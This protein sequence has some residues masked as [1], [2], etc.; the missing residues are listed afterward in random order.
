MGSPPQQ[1][2]WTWLRVRCEE[3]ERWMFTDFSAARK[4]MEEIEAALRQDTPVDILAAYCSHRAFLENQWNHFE[5]AL[6]YLERALQSWERLNNDE[7]VAEAHLDI[8]AVH[9]NRRD[10]QAAEQSLERARYFLS[11]YPE[12]QRL[13]GQLACREGFLNLHLS[14]HRKA[15]EKLQE[16]ER[17]LMALGE[18]A[19]LKDFYILT[20]VISGLGDLY[21]RMDEEDS[22]LEAYLR[23]LPIVEQH[24]LRPR[25]PWHYLNAGRAAIAQ[26]DATYARECFERVLQF[27]NEEEIE[28]K[29]HALA[30]LGILALLQ[31][32]N[33]RAAL[34]FDEAAAQFANPSSPSDFTN[35]SKIQA[36]RAELLWQLHQTQQAE[37]HFEQAYDFGKRGHDLNHL[38]H[39]CQAL[40]QL[41][42]ARGDYK[43]AYHW[44]QQSTE[45]IEQHYLQ[46]RDRERQ[47]IEIRHN[48][49][50]IRQ[51][52]QLAK[53]RVASLQQRALRA[54]MNP[55]FLFNALNAIQGLITSGR[56][57]EAETYLARFAKL[58]RHTLEYS[59][60]EV[61]TLEQEIEFLERYLDLNRR[62]RFRNRLHYTIV[63]P[64][65]VDPAE[66]FIP[67]MIVQPFVENAIEHG[68]RPRL[69]GNLKVE[70][71]LM[72]DENTLLCL[73]EDD[74][75]GFNNGREKQKAQPLS[76]QRHRSR[77]MDITR[78]RLTLLHQLHKNSGMQFIR[79][80][81]LSDKTQGERT[82]TLV[83]VIL[84]VLD[85]S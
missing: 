70:F 37:T 62:L 75:I 1:K 53:L 36:W 44:Q 4:V 31:G 69:E 63:L 5:T 72:E 50:R 42:A 48:L 83:E 71:R 58:M 59:D 12:N 57:D 80:V 38:A 18:K 28:A 2:D 13:N 74:G 32:D 49:E 6:T 10:W 55:H 35:L 41:C 47:E 7:R 43:A 40:A 67:A 76:Y 73:I 77:G 82:G 20:L 66:L 79:I 19:T 45:I 78:E 39:V 3:L 46:V 14:N 17:T 23:A 9:I 25:L 85:P 61:V 65:Q 64:T 11:K 60:L 54:Q 29:A 24:R 26:N 81:D 21:E 68:L 51:E 84:P 16:A 27:A 52:A 22:S 56:N 33:Q 15:L 8:T 34:L 30:N